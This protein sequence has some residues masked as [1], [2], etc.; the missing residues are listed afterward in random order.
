M[1]YESPPIISLK[2]Y[3]WAYACIPVLLK[4]SHTLM[5]CSLVHDIVV[6]LKIFWLICLLTSSCWLRCI[7][8]INYYSKLKRQTDCSMVWLSY[9]PVFVSLSF[10][11]CICLVSLYLLEDTCHLCCNFNP[12]NNWVSIFYEFLKLI[13]VCVSI[14]RFNQISVSFSCFLVS[15]PV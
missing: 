13:F 14:N 3:M 12:F 6:L 8:F 9:F 1:I 10:I 15:Y 2:M 4:Y 11:W 7:I 5:I